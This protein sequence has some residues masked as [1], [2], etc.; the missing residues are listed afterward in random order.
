MVRPITNTVNQIATDADIQSEMKWSRI[1]RLR[2]SAYERMF[3]GIHQMI[4]GGFMQVQVMVVDSSLADH[5]AYS[6]GDADLGFTKFMFTVLFN[7]VKNQG[8]PQKLYAF[9]DDRVTKHRPEDTMQFLNM[10]AESR[11][12]H[13]IPPFKTVQFVKS[14]KSRLVQLADLMAGI[15]GYD[16]NM[17]HAQLNAARHKVEMVDR[18]R[19]EFGVASFGIATPE[20][21]RPGLRIWKLN[22]RPRR[23]RHRP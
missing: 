14:E 4:E 5:K 2:V 9:L 3:T 6:D 12:G 7:Y 15:V 18:L 23:V 13:Q 8:Q 22:M 19:Q 20:R 16:A 1:S 21:M 11:C 17:R 10:K